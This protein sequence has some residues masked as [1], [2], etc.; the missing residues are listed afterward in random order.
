MEEWMN[1]WENKWKTLFVCQ[2]GST[3][4]ALEKPIGGTI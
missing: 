1:Q 4:A 3:I 2:R